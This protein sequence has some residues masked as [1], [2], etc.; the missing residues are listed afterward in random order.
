VL[1]ELGSYAEVSPSGTGVKV[2]VRGK[3]PPGRRRK[4]QIEMYDRGRF[5][6][7]TGHRLADSPAIVNERGEEL[8]LLH[9]RVFGDPARKAADGK[10]GSHGNLVSGLS[11][12]ELMYRAMRATNGEKFGRLW[13]GDTSDYANCDNEGRSE[14]DLALCS[15]LAFWVGPDEAG[16]DRLFRQS[17]LYRGKWE[18]PD[19]RALTLA[20][21]LD[22]EEFWSG[23]G[24]AT[25]RR[26]KVYARRE[27]VV[28]RG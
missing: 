26:G 21:A 9:S 8:R 24:V 6:T 14:A 15:M 2:F 25:L 19:Y 20:A 22:R 3:L 28:R 12:N 18:R 16:I 11:D 23:D 13:A 17:G 4:G 5:F 7:T 10:R 1:V 27:G